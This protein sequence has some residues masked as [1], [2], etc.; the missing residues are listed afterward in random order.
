MLFYTLQ[1]RHFWTKAKVTL[2]E[3]DQLVWYLS[4]DNRNKFPSAIVNETYFYR[5]C[6]HNYATPTPRARARAII[7]LQE[8]MGSITASIIENPVETFLKCL[9]TEL[10]R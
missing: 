9:A 7:R 4:F 6:K 5:F 3:I 8:S 2:A 1:Q 10:I